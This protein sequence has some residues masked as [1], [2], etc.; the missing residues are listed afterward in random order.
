MRMSS[1]SGPE[2]APLVG[3]LQEWFQKWWNRA[4][5]EEEWRLLYE[6]IQTGNRG[7]VDQLTPSELQRW[8]RKWNKRLA[9]S[10][11]QELPSERI[12][13]AFSCVGDIVYLLDQTELDEFVRWA[14]EVQFG[15]PGK[16]QD[17]V[18]LAAERARSGLNLR[19]GELVKESW[20]VADV[21][22]ALLYAWQPGRSGLR[23]NLADA[24]LRSQMDAYAGSRRNARADRVIELL[25]GAAG[26]MANVLR[27]LDLAVAVH[28][29]YH[30][31]E[32]AGMCPDCLK[33]M[34]LADG[35]KDYQ[36]AT[37]GLP[38]HPRRI[39]II[40]SY[41]PEPG[42]TLRPRPTINPNLQNF[43]PEKIDRQ[44]YLN[45][46][47]VGLNARGWTNICLQ[48]P[49]GAVLPVIDPGD[50]VLRGEG[51]PFFPLFGDWRIQGNDFVFTVADDSLM[52]Q[53][54]DQFDYVMLSGV[55][56][57]ADPLMMARDSSGT[58]VNDAA[59]QFVR[60]HLR[61]QLQVLA[62]KGTRLHMEISG[63]RNPQLVGW[64][65]EA[66]A[67]IVKSA[68]INQEELEDITGGAGFRASP[69]FLSDRP[70]RND[71]PE[72]FVRRY[73][74]A[75]KLASAFSLDQLYVHGNDSDLILARGI[76]RGAIWQE[77]TADLFVK[78][79]VVL[80][81]LQRSY[82]NWQEIAERLAIVLKRDGFTNLLEIADFVART[83][84]AVPHEQPAVL[85]DVA[86]NGYWF[87][88]DPDGYSGIVV[89]VMWPGLPSELTTAGAGDATSAA[90]AVLGRK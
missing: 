4:P 65:Q 17:F 73:Q 87:N 50:Q 77:L 53:V 70:G 30:S 21:L 51:W 10:L 25:G 37:E 75:V 8:I 38:G 39:S 74:R 20:D 80:A 66:I 55:Q 79:A 45:L 31:P 84:S 61:R 43:G 49:S 5:G 35:V 41:A 6:L 83:A 57:V 24:H 44:I 23:P 13:C 59:R 72:S 1:C 28:W 64:V 16:E 15:S 33:R 14:A 46:F 47:N 29:P 32:I 58:E 86:F 69:Y 54:A 22:G 90:F 68:G 78:G 71:A 36:P 88:R 2:S 18:N 76:Q 82:P 52:E 81:L 26:N 63:F 3:Q 60:H 67:G 19:G 27:A 7:L 56:A 42:P 62:R 12:L 85:R 11:I 40:F 9:S 48:D 34:T 89:P